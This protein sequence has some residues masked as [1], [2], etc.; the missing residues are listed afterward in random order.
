M[1]VYL[2]TFRSEPLSN[3]LPEGASVTTRG[4]IAHRNS[5]RYARAPLT[6]WTPLSKYTTAAG[7]QQSEA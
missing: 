4:G 6:S 5:Q 1:A 7:T 3:Q 2:V